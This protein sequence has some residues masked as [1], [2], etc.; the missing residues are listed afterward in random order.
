MQLTGSLVFVWRSFVAQQKQDCAD[1]QSFSVRNDNHPANHIHLDQ[2]K[3]RENYT[4]V[5]IL[6]RAIWFTSC[7]QLGA[8]VSFTDCLVSL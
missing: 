5:V 6:E 2:W 3:R 8:A 1:F 4:Y 7:K